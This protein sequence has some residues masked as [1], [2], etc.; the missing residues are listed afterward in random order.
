MLGDM[1]ITLAVLGA[2]QK[3]TMMAV[4]ALTSSL[5]QPHGEL[6]T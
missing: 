1:C 2:V 3:E 6:P 4:R 5:Y